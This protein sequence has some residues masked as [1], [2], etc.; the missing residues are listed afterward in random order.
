MKAAVYRQ[1]GQPEVLVYEDV[2]DPEIGPGDVLVKVE[3]ISIEGGDTLNRSGTD[4]GGR[5]H[6][7]GYQAAGTV[8]AT[9]AEVTTFAEGDRVVT[10]GLDGS[11]AELRAVPAAFCWRVPDALDIVEASAVP[12]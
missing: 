11:H 2:P 6:I 9:G 4:T 5:V 1:P 10:V 12:I 7:V 8:V 3:A